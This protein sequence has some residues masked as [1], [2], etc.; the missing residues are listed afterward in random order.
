MTKQE[1]LKELSF[2]NHFRNRGIGHL[3]DTLLKRAVQWR[4]QIFFEGFN[5]SNEFQLIEAQRAIIESCINSFI[6]KV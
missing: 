2:A 4:P 6:D 5:D 3:N 1:N